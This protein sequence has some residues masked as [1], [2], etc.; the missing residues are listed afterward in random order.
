M[1]FLLDM[2]ISP[3]TATFLR[4]K[5]HKAD[6]VLDLQLSRATDKEIIE[7][8]RRLGCV[9]LTHDLDFG[10]LMAAGGEQLPSVA[11]FRLTDMRPANV[12]QY[13]EVLIERYANVLIAGAI[14]SVNEHRIRVRRLPVHPEDR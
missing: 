11:I 1:D 7:M 2:G 6:H 8:A 4:T 12:N 13:M 3:H 10:A 9:I 14:L 5:G